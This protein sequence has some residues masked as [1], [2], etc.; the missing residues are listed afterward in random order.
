M[1]NLS[2]EDIEARGIETES[3]GSG[4]GARGTGTKSNQVSNDDKLFHVYRVSTTGATT[5]VHVERLDCN[6]VTNEG[7]LSLYEPSVLTQSNPVMISGRKVIAGSDDEVASQGEK[8]MEE[9][10][11]EEE[12]EEER[13]GEMVA[14]EVIHKYSKMGDGSDCED[15]DYHDLKYDGED[16]IEVADRGRGRDEHHTER[17]RHTEHENEIR[18]S[19]SL[20]VR[21]RNDEDNYEDDDEDEDGEEEGES[22][23]SLSVQPSSLEGVEMLEEESV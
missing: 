20:F 14:A 13:E 1:E 22:R 3:R 23:M 15:D 17:M 4:I 18:E 5:G 16:H 21:V 10:R 12:E 19:S 11:L 2:N 8:G 9:E 6:T 7:Y